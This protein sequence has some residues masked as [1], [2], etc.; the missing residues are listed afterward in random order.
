MPS[1]CPKDDAQGTLCLK[2]KPLL[3]DTVYEVCSFI[4]CWN[5]HFIWEKW[6]EDG[7]IFYMMAGVFLPKE[8]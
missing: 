6:S 5:G 8:N 4:I 1:P 2:N 7:W 3:Y